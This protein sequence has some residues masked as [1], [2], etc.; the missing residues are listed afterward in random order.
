MWYGQRIVTHRRL[1][2]NWRPDVKLGIMQPYFFPYLG[3]FALIAHVDEW[4]VFDVTQY[5]PKTWMNRNRVLHPTQGWNYVNVPLANSSI[6]IRTH[7]ARILDLAEARRSVL[8][9]LSHYKRRA[10]YYR[11]VEALVESVMADS[12]NPSLVNLNVRSLRATCEYLGLQFDYRICSDLD[13]PLPE[14]LEPG[15]WA[16]TICSMLEASAYVNPAGGRDLFAPKDFVSRNIS[17]EFL[18]FEAFVYETNPYQFES[19][20]SILDVMM[21]NSPQSIVEAMRSG[22]TVSAA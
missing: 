22:T 12:D 4:L 8:G 6:S 13:L 18:S 20:L 2:G 15:Q 3:H 10:P 11:A 7:E 14:R 9:K 16:P 19:G 21:W 1:P 17:L 5:T